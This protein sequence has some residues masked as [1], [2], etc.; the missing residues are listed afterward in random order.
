M[1]AIEFKGVEQMMAKLKKH[2]LLVLGR[3][4]A[5]KRNIIKKIFTDLVEHSPQWSGNLASNW[6]IEFHGKTGSY[7]QNQ[8]YVPPDMFKWK[9]NPQQ[10]GND[11]AV[12]EALTRELPKLAEIRW[13]SKVRIMNY[14]PYASDVEQNIGP[15]SPIW[16][17][18]DIREEN[19]LASY[20]GVAMVGYVIMKYKNLRNLKRAM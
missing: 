20:G 12:R 15:V 14:T 2:E 18:R 3:V 7:V 17:Q 13:N 8:N 5:T 19:K 1:A 9:D 11:P 6:Y 4:T 16:G 10:M